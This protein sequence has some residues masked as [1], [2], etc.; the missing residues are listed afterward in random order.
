MQSHDQLSADNMAAE[1][2]NVDRIFHRRNNAEQDSM[3]KSEMLTP[4]FIQD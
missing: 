1:M 4:K 3:T 2:V